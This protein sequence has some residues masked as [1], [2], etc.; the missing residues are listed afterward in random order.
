MIRHA[1]SVNETLPN[2]GVHLIEVPHE[3]NAASSPEEVAAICAKL[4]QL[5]KSEFSDDGG[6]SWRQVTK[7]DMV[8]VALYN[9]QVNRLK[10]ALPEG[11]AVGTV[12]KF[13][14]QEAPIVVVSMTTSDAEDS[15]RGA[16][17]VLSANRLNFAISRAQV[18]ALVFASPSLLAPRLGKLDHLKQLNHLLSLSTS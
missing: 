12:D 13:Q 11:V 7:E 1:E 8:V 16:D 5:L 18:L 15:P 2:E 10:A 4:Q 6:Q 14:G 17:F 9:V 3:G